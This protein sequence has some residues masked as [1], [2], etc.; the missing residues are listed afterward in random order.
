MS[1]RELETVRR[2]EAKPEDWTAQEHKWHSRQSD[3][4]EQKIDTRKILT[5]LFLARRAKHGT[6]C[7]ESRSQSRIWSWMFAITPTKKV[8]AKFRSHSPGQ[9]TTTKCDISDIWNMQQ[10]L[11]TSTS[12]CATKPFLLR[13]RRVPTPSPAHHSWRVG[14][15]NRAQK[16]KRRPTPGIVGRMVAGQSDANTLAQTRGWKWCNASWK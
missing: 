8:S 5:C 12:S 7:V 13:S 15:V 1:R 14:H 11:K 2:E 10:T 9:R 4:C 3:G 6:Q 16:I